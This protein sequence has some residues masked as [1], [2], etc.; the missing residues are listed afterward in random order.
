MTRTSRPP[1]ETFPWAESRGRVVHLYAGGDAKASEDTSRS[2][3]RKVSLPDVGG[4]KDVAALRMCT[5]PRKRTKTNISVA[6][7]CGPWGKWGR[8]CDIKNKCPRPEVGA[9]DV[10]QAKTFIYGQ[11]AEFV[12]HSSCYSEHVSLLGKKLPP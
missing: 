8:V 1:M 9:R 7:P 2:T 4:K 6:G 12:W 11:V 5:E 3:K 10:K